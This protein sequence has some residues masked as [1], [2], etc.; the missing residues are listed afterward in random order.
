LIFG[1]PAFVKK[2]SAYIPFRRLPAGAAAQAGTSRRAGDIRYCPEHRK[3]LSKSQTWLKIEQQV[4]E[5]GCSKWI[6]RGEY[7]ISISE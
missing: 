6:L 1:V 4:K 2:T 3:E 5:V 7:P